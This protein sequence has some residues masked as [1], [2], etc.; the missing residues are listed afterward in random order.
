MDIEQ[1]KAEEKQDLDINSTRLPRK[2]RPS[3][4][5]LSTLL[6]GKTGKLLS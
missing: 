1:E 5:G 4:L 6:G 2:Q 3:L